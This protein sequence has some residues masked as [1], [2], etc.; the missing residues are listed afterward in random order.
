M[1][2][3]RDAFRELYALNK[4]PRDRRNY[5]NMALIHQDHCQHG[6]ERFLPWH[7]VYLY[8]FEQALQD[9]AP[10]VTMPYWDFTM[11]QYR[12]ECPDEGVDHPPVLPGVPHPRGRGLAGARTPCP[13]CR[14]GSPRR[15]GED[16]GAAVHVAAPLLHRA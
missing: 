6:W 1:E 13:S 4:W 8:E 16:G 2:Q 11:P 12:P 7:R 10:G 5:N 9:V 3:L 15:C 14:P